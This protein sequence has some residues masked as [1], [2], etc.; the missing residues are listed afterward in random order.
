MRNNTFPVRAVRKLP[1]FD[2]KKTPVLHTLLCWPPYFGFILEGIKTFEIRK[3]DRNFKEG[4]YLRLREYNPKQEGPDKYTGRLL[5]ARIGYILT[6]DLD[7]NFGL[8]PGYC[9]I[10]LLPVTGRLVLVKV[11]ELLAWRELF[12]N[13][14][15]C[16]NC[17]EDLE[18]DSGYYAT[19]DEPGQPESVYCPNCL[20]DYPIDW[21]RIDRTLESMNVISKE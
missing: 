20:I 17:G 19:Q 11:G 3:N 9:V 6:P 16:L 5:Y 12:S 14:D 2:K 4:D 10:G 21:G 18:Y 8:E 1:E 15:L 13:A 7:N